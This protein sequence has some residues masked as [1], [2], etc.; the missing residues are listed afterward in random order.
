MAY[1][2]FYPDE[3]KYKKRKKL[4]SKCK[5]SCKIGMGDTYGCY[6]IVTTGE[7]PIIFSDDGNVDLRGD[8][9]TTCKLYEKGARK[10]MDPIKFR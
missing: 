9:L 2:K 1:K 7:S 10:P 5:H 3:R 6:Y 4:C 8:D